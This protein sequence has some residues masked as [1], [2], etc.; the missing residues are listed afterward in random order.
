MNSF[1]DIDKKI[2]DMAQ[3]AEESCIEAFK[4]IDDITEYNQNKVLSAFIKNKVSDVHMNATTGYGYNDIGREKIESLFANITGSEDSLFRHN[5]MS[6][7]HAITVALF[8]ILRPGD[9]ILSVTGT[10]YDTLHG[11]IGLK[12]SHGSLLAFGIKYE[13]ADLHDFEERLQKSP[14]KAV[15]IQRSRGY[16]L[17]K[18]LTVANIEEICKKTRSIQPDAIIIVDNC[19]GEFTQKTEPTQHGADIIIGSLIKNPGGG[20]APTG[21]YIAGKADL[22][23]MCA[24]RLTAPG[25]G[26]EIGATLGLSRQL[27]MGLYN[28]PHITGESLKAAVFAAALFEMMGYK[29]DPAP[30]SERGDIIQAIIL[31]NEQ[32]LIAFMKGLQSGSPIDSHVTPIAADMP[33][34]EEKVIMAAGAFTQGSTAEMSADAP[35]KPP[36]AAFIQGS[37]NYHSGKTAIMLAANAVGTPSGCPLG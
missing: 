6:G 22:V 16:S 31:Q 34:Y 21:G 24:N 19:Y 3:K 20:I 2:I 35:L 13:E 7:T 30:D 18:A 8:G 10:P 27:Y 28:A 1:F 26:R 29:A 33:G 25:V 37:L 15:Y 12:K 11:V 9:T 36:Y 5:F 32:K 4:K 17:R 23:E 14:V